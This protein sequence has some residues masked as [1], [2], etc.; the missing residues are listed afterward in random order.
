MLSFSLYFFCPFSSVLA[1]LLNFVFLILQN[2]S[3][4]AFLFWLFLS[5]SFSRFVPYWVSLSPYS[6]RNLLHALFS[7]SKSH[8]LPYTF[9]WI[10][11]EFMCP[12]GCVYVDNV[13][14]LFF[15]AR[16]AMELCAGCVDSDSQD[17]S[18]TL[19]CSARNGHTDCVRLLIDA[20]AEKEAKSNVRHWSMCLMRRQFL[21]FSPFLALLFLSARLCSNSRFRFEPW[22]IAHCPF[23]AYLPW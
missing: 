20:G 21:F 14:L 11:R 15:S 4:N 2:L 18:T 19:I 1:C 16:C 6:C 13:F 17:G 10:N 5:F 8:P 3:L 22:W 9:L 7:L 23:L 12:F